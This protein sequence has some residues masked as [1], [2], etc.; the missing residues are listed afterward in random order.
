M[1]I[2]R[3]IIYGYA[4]VLGVAVVGIQSGFAIGNHY[5]RRALEVRQSATAESRLLRNLQIRILNN[6]PAKQL[7]PYL[8]S[9]QRFQQESQA[10][11]NRVN[12]I[13]RILSNLQ[14]A[15][16]SGVFQNSQFGVES[17][18]RSEEAD[19]VSGD[20]SDDISRADANPNHPSTFAPEG[21]DE[22]SRLWIDDLA[23]YQ[24]TVERL[25]D[26]L[27]SFI[28]TVEGL[29]NT[30]DDLERARVALLAFEQSPEFTTFIQFPDQMASFIDAVNNKEELAEVE[31]RNA[32]LLRQQIILGTLILSVAIA[33]A[34][35]LYTSHVIAHPIQTVTRMAQ[36][37]TDENNFTLQVAVN[38]G[39]EVGVLAASINQL[40]QQV[41]VLLNQ[42]EKKNSDLEGLLTKVHTQQIQLVQS[43]KMS[44]LGQL[45]AGVAHEINNPVNFIHGNLSYAQQY[46]KD[47]L[48]ILELYQK[49]YPTP[50]S[51]IQEAAEEVDLAFIQ[52]D[53][54]NM[55]NSMRLGTNRIR[56]IVLS[57]RNF[58]RL[59]EAEFKAVDIHEGIDSTLLI[60]KHR[61][62]EHPHRPAIA[63]IKDYGAL[64]V[65]S[66][67]PSQFNQVIMN[68]LSNAIDA[69]EDLHERTLRN[70]PTASA[71]PYEITIRTAV[72][73]PDW[74]EIAIADNG[75]GI[76]DA[77]KA[78]IFDPFFTTKE[79]GQGTGMGMSISYQII[80]ENHGGVLT[81]VSEPGNG[82]EFIIQI[83][84][85]Q[86]DR[87]R[88][89]ADGS[90]I[91]AQETE[92]RNS[93]NPV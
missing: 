29:S 68:I 56:E 41:R 67:Y 33:G 26:R 65:V 45:V 37:V 14:T 43:E 23:E 70:N 64:P 87:S 86:R 92:R 30:P 80:T 40:I 38:R 22:E 44:S 6:R 53:F 35:A 57:L 34:I 46:A 4:L 84:Q 90:G 15:Y 17:D 62:K 36:R 11:L 20:V 24:L 54:P 55:L 21:I 61:L 63:I 28:T 50:V 3:R 85:R 74:V 8:A 71:S 5:Q 60:L 91:A 47:L 52:T 77:V 72:R 27:Q 42:L 81:C 13:Q 73:E 69:L 66:C 75:P 79:I 89:S 88:A 78:H 25:H 48:S 93:Q 16:E 32:E 49:H 83:P 10:M 31:L 9:S 59:D 2:R 7:S 1:T 51:A 76:P 39:T 18:A 82:A 12:D 58:S 19:D